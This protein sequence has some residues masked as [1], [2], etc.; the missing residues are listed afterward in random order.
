MRKAL[1]LAC[2]L[3]LTAC[4]GKDTGSPQS[5]GG[6][7]A[8]A[9]TKPATGGPLTLGPEGHAVSLG[10][11]EDQVTAAGW[12]IDTNKQSESAAKCPKTATIDM[13]GAQGDLIISPKNGVSVINGL[14]VMRTPEGI[15]IDSPLAD[16]TKAYPEAKAPADT[17]VYTSL[18][19]PVPGNAK[20]TYE[21]DFKNKKVFLF[22]L[23]LNSNEC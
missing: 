19:V 17:G 12:T 16:V 18:A 10:A 4:G 2:L 6:S 23:K 20:A 13:D 5:T 1:V 14:G 8:T 7:P 21:F 3:A 11:T 9:A 22:H 15:G